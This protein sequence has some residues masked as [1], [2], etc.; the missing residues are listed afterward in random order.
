[1]PSCTFVIKTNDGA[2][3]LKLTVFNDRDS[4][5][6]ALFADSAALD[7]EDVRFFF[8]AL[9]SVPLFK[10]ATKESYGL[11]GITVYNVVS[12]DS[13]R[14]KFKFWSPRKRGNPQEHQLVEAVIG[15]SRRKFKSLKQQQY[16]ESLEQY[17]DFGLPCRVTSTEPF[18]VR[19]YGGLSLGDDEAL[20]TFLRGLPA[21]K[22]LLIDMT[23]FNGMGTRF[24]P[25]FHHLL[26]RNPNV[27]WVAYPK[28]HGFMQLLE[29]G[30]AR[31]RIDTTMVDGR[32]TIKRLSEA[33]N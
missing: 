10:M 32:N 3:R 27:V 20:N 11:D 31:D 21:D 23:N 5:R 16:V 22:P 28:A 19:I 4:L 13:L 18:E 12:Q 26:K 9:D 6:T 7:K 2:G 1:M 29:I 30:V 8:A 15:L 24:Y 14:N 25:L 33:L 17:F